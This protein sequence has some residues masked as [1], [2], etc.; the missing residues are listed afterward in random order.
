MVIVEMSATIEDD[1]T[2]FNTTPT[3]TSSSI[4][5]SIPLRL[6]KLT[7]SPITKTI[8]YV[9]PSLVSSIVSKMFAIHDTTTA[10]PLLLASS[11]SSPP[12]VLAGRQHRTLADMIP[13]P[14]Y[15]LAAI[16]ICV[17]LWPVYIAGAITYR[18]APQ[19]YQRRIVETLEQL[20][21]GRFLLP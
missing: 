1:I 20:G 21:V 13:R 15:R 12:V 9:T 17:M 7:P 10:T 4:I 8:T 16:L 2:A 6:W 19:V 14:I 3:P 5:T 18:F 11:P